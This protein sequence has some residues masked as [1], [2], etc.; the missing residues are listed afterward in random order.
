VRANGHNSMPVFFRGQAW[1]WPTVVAYAFALGGISNAFQPA[2]LQTSR[3]C[4]CSTMML[5]LSHG[6]ML[7]A[8]LR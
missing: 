1:L 5:A 7:S 8:T 3:H 4:T 2:H 6:P